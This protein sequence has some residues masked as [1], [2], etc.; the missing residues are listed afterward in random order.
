MDS[1]APGGRRGTTRRRQSTSAASP[2]RQHR[3]TNFRLGLATCLARGGVFRGTFL[4][5]EMGGVASVIEPAVSAFDFALRVLLLRNYSWIFDS[6]G[7]G[8]A[9]LESGGLTSRSNTHTNQEPLVETPP[10]PHLQTH[11]KNPRPVRFERGQCGRSRSGK[12]PS[13]FMSE[14]NPNFFSRNNQPKLASEPKGPRT[15]FLR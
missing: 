3:E 7:G 4:L 11:K 8:C 9:S 5:P 14:E 1:Q 10:P 12:L 13:K 6:G 2:R 15:S